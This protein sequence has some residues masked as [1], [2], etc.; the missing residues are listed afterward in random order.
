[1]ILALESDNPS[2]WPPDKVAEFVVEE[3][4]ELLGRL[5]RIS[6][7]VTIGEVEG[8]SEGSVAAFPPSLGIVWEGLLSPSLLGCGSTAE[9][10]GVEIINGAG[11]GEIGSGLSGCISTGIIGGSAWMIV[12]SVGHD[13]GGS[14]KDI[15]V[16]DVNSGLNVK[17][18]V[19]IFTLLL[20]EK[21]GVRAGP[22][23][24][25]SIV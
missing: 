7:E 9:S 18:V 10:A 11:G 25:W 2:V 14:V 12:G 21:V 6:E 15:G 1:M 19:G 13:E 23:R 8:V 5:W 22:N 20:A 4:E 24:R 17:A 3:C 16:C